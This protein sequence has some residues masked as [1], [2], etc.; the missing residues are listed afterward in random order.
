MAVDVLKITLW[1]MRVTLVDFQVRLQ[2][3]MSAYIIIGPEFSKKQF[4]VVIVN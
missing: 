2:C 3:A 1:F 4:L